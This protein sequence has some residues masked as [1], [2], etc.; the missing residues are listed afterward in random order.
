M[1]RWFL[2]DRISILVAEY[3]VRLKQSNVQVL[4]IERA[5]DMGDQ[6]QHQLRFR[7]RPETISF[8]PQ[9]RAAAIQL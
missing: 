8:Q 6:G 9:A 7:F 2:I 5:A 1:G 3:Q 4:L